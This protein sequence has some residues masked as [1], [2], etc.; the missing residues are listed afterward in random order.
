MFSSNANGL[1]GVPVGIGRDGTIAFADATRQLFSKVTGDYIDF[2][3]GTTDIITNV[4]SYLG[5]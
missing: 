2:K 5:S 3:N 4:V 1:P